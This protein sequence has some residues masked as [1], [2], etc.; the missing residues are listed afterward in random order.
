MIDHIWVSTNQNMYEGTIPLLR[1]SVRRNAA[2][3]SPLILPLIQDELDVYATKLERLNHEPWNAVVSSVNY[4]RVSGE[5]CRC[6]YTVVGQALRVDDIWTIHQAIRDA[7]SAV[8]N[9]EMAVDVD[10]IG[11]KRL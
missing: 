7:V 8:S 11:A 9:V 3:S 1:E 5:M 6:W 2:H 4:T 10:F